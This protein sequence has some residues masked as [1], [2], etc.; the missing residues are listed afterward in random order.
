MPL[1]LLEKVYHKQRRVYVDYLDDHKSHKFN[2]LS[3]KAAK[4][5]KFA[6]KN[7]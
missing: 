4:T 3:L 7:H 6:R 2:A 5:L 1:N